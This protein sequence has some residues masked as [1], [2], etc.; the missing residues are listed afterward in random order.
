M[1]R[2]EFFRSIINTRAR[3]F[4][5]LL[6]VMLGVAFFSGVR[7]AGPDMKLSADKY[8]DDTNLQDIRIVSTL[9]LT[10]DD[11]DAIR[12]VDGVQNVE[13]GYSCDV[14]A[15][16]NTSQLIMRFMSL[17][18]KISKVTLVSGRFPEKD[19]ECLVDTNFAAKSGYKIGDTFTVTT[20][21][22]TKLSDE[23]KADQYT[24]V[25]TG[26]TPLFLSLERGSSTIGSGVL[27]SYVFVPASSFAMDVYTQAVLT[28][29]GASG[30]LCYSDEY[31]T[32]IGNI[33]DNIG[34]IDK[35][36]C[37]IRYA[38]VKADGQAEIDD[39]RAQIEK[40]KNELSDAKKKLT[41]AQQ[42]LSDA[43]A[44]VSEKKQEILDGEQEISEKQ[45][46]I[47]SGK[48]KLSDGYD[49][50]YAGQDEL[51]SQIDTL[52][53]G[54]ARLAEA[55]SQYNSGEAQYTSGLAQYNSGLAQWNAA[56]GDANLEKISDGLK[57]A[58]AAL[59]QTESALSQLQLS[60]EADK[61][62]G[63]DAAALAQ[64]E[65]KI[66]ALNENKKSISDQISA[67][68][69]Q[70][71]KLQ[72]EKSKLDASK[73]TL[74][75]SRAQLDAASAE[76]NKNQA[77]I[78]AADEKITAAQAQL[79]ASYQE[80]QENEATL[81]DGQAK[82]D[83][84]KKELEDGKN[85]LSEAESEISSHEQELT[86]AQKKYDE[87]SADAEKEIKANESKL[88]DAQK[89]LDELEKPTWYVLNRK[90]LTSYTEYGQNTERIVAIG[91]VFP[92]IFF[93]V[94]ALV[95][96]TTMTRM[97]EENRE[98]V[99]TLKALG[100]KSR[101]IASK[102]IAYALI[103]TMTGSVAGFLLGQK[104]LPYFIIRA[105]KILYDNLPEILLPIH[106]MLS[107]TAT[108]AAIGTTT[109]S[110]AFACIKEATAVPAD[111]MRPLAPPSGKRILLEKIDFLWKRLNFS[112]KATFR[113]LFRYKKRFFMTVLGIGGCMGLLLTGFGLKDS[114]MAIGTIQF[115]KIDFH[116]AD[117]MFSD[118]ILQEKQN[119]IY[120]KVLSDE[121]TK[122]AVPAMT[123]TMDF[124][125]DGND[126]KRSGYVVVPK[127]TENFSDYISMHDRMTGETYRLN[128]D[129]VVLTEK[130]ASLMNVHA[131]DEFYLY[132]S[133]TE[134]YKVR[135]SAVM[136]NYF[137]HYA[138]ISPAYYEKIFGE[139]PEY[140]E[141]I[142]KM[143]EADTDSENGFRS[144]M[145]KNDGISGINFTTAMKTRIANM[146]K[147]MDALIY[148]VVLAAGA[149]A[150]IVLYNLNNIN[151]EERKREL[152]TLKVLGFQN[153]EISA[154]VLREN[155]WLTAMGAAAGVFFGIP[156]H[157][158]L[159][160]TAE[161]EIMMFGRSINPVSY[162]YSIGLT[163]LFASLVNVV[164]HFSLKKIDMVESLKSIE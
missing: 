61:A 11:I 89:E 22:D 78:D 151:I 68:N 30:L 146:L 94:A 85:K 100:Y 132:K 35:D 114:I 3:F 34:K 157:Y 98:Q 142:V 9:G 147:S 95:C 131:G 47:D 55:V 115:G 124:A 15:D 139:K 26:I 129:G 96:L 27:N 152:A 62:A 70:Q 58:N 24:I 118:G 48:Q 20:P 42:Q 82:L 127:D 46:E 53:A 133:D 161:I 10:E 57:T 155:V 144:R 140:N 2:K 83:E 71:A 97:V 101:T 14:F 153:E 52:N 162:L 90:T 43:K 49:A 163:L 81:A 67:L 69:A 109:L 110:A 149:L 76:I 154:Y 60:Y 87:K 19:G 72:E 33:E 7:A 59:A 21:E 66:S 148:V 17:P 54:K 125:V 143:K 103:A 38:S 99:G 65:A 105:Y 156:L 29:K 145:M 13:P 12:K 40:A 160:R 39:A 32:L 84:A 134:K 93:L 8:Y 56:G 137:Y 28:V 104:L 119:N 73:A 164:M 86:D 23:L 158:F 122:E 37:N 113:N 112:Q 6:I 51:N 41:D 77:D 50:Y 18:E 135:I 136:E 150:F 74:D 88:D 1:L 117:V 63:A 45:E 75:T 120:S 25:G 31:D 107:F 116:D 128:D 92:V 91:D 159:I 44:E 121:N 4:S 130:I 138:Y 16:S 5:I 111:L 79:D 141:I 106:P 123:V 108:A 64:T 126:E 36:R 102:Y 80:L